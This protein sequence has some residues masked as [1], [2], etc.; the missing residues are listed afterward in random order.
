M[1]ARRAM[2]LLALSAC[3]PQDDG[4]SDPWADWFAGS[5]TVLADSHANVV[6]QFRFLS[7]SDDGVVPGFDLDGIDDS[8]ASSPCGFE[9]GVDGAGTRGVDNQ[10]GR[11]WG[12]IEGLVGEQVQELLQGSINEGRF[13]LLIELDDLRNDDDVTVLIARGE[14]APWIGGQGVIAPDQSFRIDPS[15]PVSRV[16]G[17]AIVD[18]VL[19]AGPVDFTLPIDI[20]E[21][22]FPLDVRDGRL[23]L[24]IGRDGRFAGMIGGHIDVDFAIGELLQTDAAAEAALVPGDD[25][26]CTFM[27][28]AFGFDATNAFVVHDVAE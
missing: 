13:L 18:G 25:G 15:I 11:M 6:Q 16:D 17:V 24:E 3:A 19:E 28:A 8:E 4:A 9:D 14:G 7:E 21:A 1:T 5:E 27:S 26:A 10:F 12:L 20:L 2:A 22:N 23:R